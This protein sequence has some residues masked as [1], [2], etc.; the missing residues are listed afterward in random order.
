MKA[1]LGTIGIFAAIVAFVVPAAGA[2]A[3]SLPAGLTLTHFEL[4]GTHGYKI[5]GGE[6]READF[7][8][9]AVVTAHRSGLRATYEVPGELEPGMHAVF[10]AVGSADLDFQRRKRMVDRPEKGCVW[11]TETGIFQ[12]DFSFAGED[13]YTAAAATSV[14]GE[15]TRLP[16]GFCG[17]GGDRKGR[18]PDF[19]RATQ[20]SAR[21]RIAHGFV[22]FEASAP[23]FKPG[24]GFGALVREVIG[25]MTISRTA[26]AAG[27]RSAFVL[28]PAKRPHSASV[29]PPAPFEGS[30]RLRHRPGHPP[31]WIGSL[32]ISL[33]GAPEV[34][35]AGSGFAAR[36]CLHS[37]ILGKCKIGRE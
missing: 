18:T 36:L 37:T 23:G 25:P 12:G 4:K 34:A 21:S 24:I 16:N 28:E 15:I 3:K 11:I 29:N 19:L 17:F 14:P 5:E 33:P 26:S 8:P 20:L 2:S 32:S 35:L 10:G 31:T 30:A 1:R 13:S 6:L 7:P 27:P 22:Q 9:T